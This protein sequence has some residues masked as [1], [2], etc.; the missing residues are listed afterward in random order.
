MSPPASAAMSESFQLRTWLDETLKRVVQ[1]RSTLAPMSERIRIA[2]NAQISTLPCSSKC[3][4]RFIFTPLRGLTAPFVSQI[5]CR[6]NCRAGPGSVLGG[7]CT[8]GRK[9]GLEANAGLGVLRI[10]QLDVG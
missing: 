1:L 2:P 6:K 4:T 3:F 8:T 9:D 10:C 7:Y 5:R